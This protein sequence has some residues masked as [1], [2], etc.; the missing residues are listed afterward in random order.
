[1]TQIPCIKNKCL[2]F[3]ACKSKQVIACPDLMAYYKHNRRKGDRNSLAL[4]VREYLGEI[5]AI[6][7]SEDV[8]LLDYEFIFIRGKIK[9][10]AM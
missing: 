8:E 10:H 6:K 3:P 1:M 4:K 5:L 9:D 2:M 7:K